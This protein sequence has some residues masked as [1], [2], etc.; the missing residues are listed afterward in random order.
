MTDNYMPY[1]QFLEELENAFEIDIAT[2][3]LIDNSGIRKI[4]AGMQ[5]NN[6]IQ[7]KWTLQKCT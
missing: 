4:N 3:Y 7:R 2:T 1:A 6:V 5:L